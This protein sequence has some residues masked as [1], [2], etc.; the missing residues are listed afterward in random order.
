MGDPK[1]FTHESIEF[2]YAEQLVIRMINYCINNKLNV[3][4]YA[5]KEQYESYVELKCYYE[6]VENSNSINIVKIM[7]ELNGYCETN[8]N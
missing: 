8:S 6:K 2:K 5:I 3:V 4:S 1:L 7:K